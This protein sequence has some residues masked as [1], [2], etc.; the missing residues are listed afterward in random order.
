MNI[1]Q[2][3]GFSSGRSL[4][5]LILFVAVLVGI[6]I[7]NRWIKTNL[8]EESEPAASRQLSATK[9]ESGESSAA[10]PAVIP[11]TAPSAEISSPQAMRSST[12][13]EEKKIIYETPLNS[14]I[15]LQ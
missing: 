2:I 1:F 13:Q 5:F 4:A 15:L 12:P 3:R 10:L 7:A 9:P 14:T 6:F 8:S 11:P